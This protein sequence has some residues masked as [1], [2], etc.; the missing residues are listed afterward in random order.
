MILLEVFVF[1]ILNRSNIN[2]YNNYDNLCDH[3]EHYE[4]HQSS[5]TYDTETSETSET[6]EQHRKKSWWARFHDF[7]V[8]GAFF[9]AH[10]PSASSEL[11]EQ[12]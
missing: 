9:L 1:D 12:R 4:Q 6:F 8:G 2:N 10:A 3:Y 5:D 11:L 7:H